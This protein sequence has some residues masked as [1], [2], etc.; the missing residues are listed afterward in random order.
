MGS[1]GNHTFQKED[2]AFSSFVSRGCDMNMHRRGDVYPPVDCYLSNKLGWDGSGSP[3]H[4]YMLVDG[5][6]Q[7][8][9]TGQ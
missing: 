2:I 3:V 8:Q 5:L 4:F 1:E 7:V 9:I 6:L